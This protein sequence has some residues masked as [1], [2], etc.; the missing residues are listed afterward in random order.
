MGELFRRKKVKKLNQ[1]VQSFWKY[2]DDKV[3]VGNSKL[4]PLSS[5]S[6]PLERCWAGWCN[7][8][9]EDPE[10]TK[11]AIMIHRAIIVEVVLVWLLEAD[12]KQ[13]GGTGGI[14]GISWRMPVIYLTLTTGWQ[15]MKYHKFGDKLVSL[16]LT[17]HCKVVIFN[18]STCFT[19]SF[20]FTL[21]KV[22]WQFFYNTL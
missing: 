21:V 7:V 19:H 11:G 8:F 14:Y 13:T 16:T 20:I 10:P 1:N 17:S 18:K 4:T 12:W 3:I 5:L 6:D 2:P 15:V 9:L 22:R